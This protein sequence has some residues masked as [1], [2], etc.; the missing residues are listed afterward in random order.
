M[1]PVPGV[2]DV[3]VHSRLRGATRNESPGFTHDD[4][5][6]WLLRSSL[7]EFLHSLMYAE[8]MFRKR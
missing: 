2:T 4:I 7:R 3:P 8:N 5:F 1:S 6:T